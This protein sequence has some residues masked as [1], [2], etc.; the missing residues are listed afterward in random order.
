MSESELYPGLDAELEAV[1][2]RNVAEGRAKPPEK[3]AV[4]GLETVV[5]EQLQQ[6]RPGS[7]LPPEVASWAR[8]ELDNNFAD[9]ALGSWDR[10]ESHLGQT[11]PKSL[12]ELMQTSPNLAITLEK[13]YR[14]KQDLTASNEVTPE[15]LNIGETMKLVLMPWKALRDNLDRLPDWVKELRDIQGKAS[16]DDYFYDD[17]LSALQGGISEIY[18][19]PI[20]GHFFATNGTTAPHWITAR[21]YLDQRIA[22]QGEWG[23]ML[24]QTSDD[25]GIKSIVEGPDEQRSPNAL[26]DKGNRHF[27]IAGHDVDGMGVLE[28]LCLTLQEDPTKLSSR[29]VS[30]LLANRFDINGA[31]CVPDGDWFGDRVGSGLDDA[32]YADDLWRPRLA[33]S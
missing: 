12:D 1:Y 20:G 29:D 5:E 33:V 14:A 7:N 25:A 8:V 30:W 22:T 9:G 3:V 11:V 4:S 19:N 2:Q 6:K 31:L 13:L 28:W 23:I 21:D 17:L 24:V 27:N 18:R 15:D 32:G 16:V 10:Y 26:T